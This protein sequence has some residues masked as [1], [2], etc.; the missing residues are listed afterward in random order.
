MGSQILQQMVNG[1]AL[2]CV[3]GLISLGYSMVYGILEML[4]FAHGDVFMIGGF[5]GYGILKIFMS[6]NALTAPPALVITLMIVGAMIG[7]GVLG[8][9]IE[10]LAYRPIRNAPRLAP[11]ISALAMSIFLQNFVALTLGARAKNYS[12]ELLIPT[13]WQ[14]TFLGVQISFV[15][16]L[17]IGLSIAFMIALDIFV[18]RTRFG[19][20]MRATNNDRVGASFQGISI[21]FIISLTFLIG[22]MLAGAAGVLVGLYYT[23]IDFFM[24]F[25]AGFKAFTAA[26]LGGI[27]N[28]R[29]AMLGGV[30]LGMAESI[31]IAFI[32]PTYKDVI[33]LVLLI[34]L[35]LV[36]PSGLLG[37]QLP[38][39][40]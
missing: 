3:Y 32:S 11:L 7:C 39:K 36:K 9:G 27:G 18:R 17:L 33:A 31:G 26:V 24:G 40:V 35:L 34:L 12:T 14:W 16:V 21:N 28:L 20:A 37:E 29:G 2:G 4:N 6:G 13:N 23:Q 1:L 8:M 25:T 30:V 10:F 19:K 22:S 5:I 38:Q 15:R